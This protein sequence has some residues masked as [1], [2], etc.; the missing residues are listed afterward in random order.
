M[1]RLSITLSTI[2]L[3]F[4]FSISANADFLYEVPLSLD[5]PPPCCGKSTKVKPVKAKKR[6]VSRSTSCTVVRQCANGC[7]KVYI[8]T[9]PNYFVNFSYD[10]AGYASKPKQ[11]DY[12]TSDMATGDDNASIHPDLQISH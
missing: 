3:L 8:H 7:Q 9:S 6:Y 12:Y 5:A 11:E 2:I 1:M 4:S 10:P